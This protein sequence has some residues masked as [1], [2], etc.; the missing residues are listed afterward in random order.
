MSI[1]SAETVGDIMEEEVR[2]LRKR[3]ARCSL[4]KDNEVDSLKSRRTKV[5]KKKQRKG[6]VIQWTFEKENLLLELYQ[7]QLRASASEKSLKHSSWAIITTCMKKQ[8]PEDYFS[9]EKCRNKFNSLRQEYAAYKSLKEKSGV[10]VDSPDS[11]W[12]E[13][14]LQNPLVNKFRDGSTF[15]HY[16]KMSDIVG[17]HVFSGK[18]MQT[19][20]SLTTTTSDECDDELLYHQVTTTRKKRTAAE[21]SRIMEEIYVDEITSKAHPHPLYQRTEVFVG[22]EL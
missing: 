4:D 10:E 9:M 14:I 6:P 11:V 3:S 5:E 2:P 20:M 13:L 21:K 12:D 1:K 22:V 18:H 17:S 8:F 15:A 19:P 7:Q 16:E